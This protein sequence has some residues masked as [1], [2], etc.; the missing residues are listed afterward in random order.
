[1]GNDFSFVKEGLSNVQKGDPNRAEI[2]AIIEDFKESV[3]QACK[4]LFNKDVFF[5]PVLSPVLGRQIMPRFLMHGGNTGTVTVYLASLS[6]LRLFQYELDPILGY[7]VTISYS[8]KTVRCEGRPELLEAIKDAYNLSVGDLKDFCES[9][10]KWI[11]WLSGYTPLS[12]I[13][14]SE[15]KG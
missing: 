4:T 11:R 13:A 8:S 7:P 15:N 3:R 2:H 14:W 10:G 5:E 1:M 12:S 9:G 6:S